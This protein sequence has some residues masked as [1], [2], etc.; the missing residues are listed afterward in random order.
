MHPSDFG[1]TAP[2]RVVHTAAEYWAYIPHPLPPPLEPDWE[3]TNVAADAHAALGELSGLMRSLPNPHLLFSPFLRR[4]AVLSS[5]IEGTQASLGDLAL[6]EAGTPGLVRSP[7]VREVANYVTALEHGLERR[8]VLP[9]SLRL[10]REMHG[11]LMAGPM[12]AH[13]T[14]G[15]FRRSQN[16]IGRPG[17]T[18]ANATY[19]PPPAAELMSTLDAFERYLH[20]AED[21]PPVIRLALIHYQFEA[22]HPFLDGNGRIGRLLILLLLV[23]WGLLPGP[24]LVLSAYFERTRPAYYAR[25][26]AVSQQGAWRSWIEYFVRGIAD[27]SRDA[28]RRSGR[29]LALR[30]DYRSRVQRDTRVSGSVLRLVDALFESP[31]ITIPRTAAAYG[32]T[33]RTVQLHVARLEALGILKESTGRQRN[34]VFIAPGILNILADGDESP[35]TTA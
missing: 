35:F 24:A 18:L 29:L 2:G 14:P 27:E 9:V 10:I 22:I 8:Q 21:L 30:D 1:P 12:A 25:L 4:E 32:L 28:I 6:H 5:R 31:A 16:W 3:I 15:E 7:D 26:L 13:L 19:V 33:Q 34:R 17:S 20:M 23:D 11:K